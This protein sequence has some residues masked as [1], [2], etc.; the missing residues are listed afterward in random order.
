MIDH[1]HARRIK[2][3]QK[4]FARTFIP[5]SNLQGNLNQSVNKPE[6][7]LE[8]NTLDQIMAQLPEID[9]LIAGAAPER[10]IKDMNKLD[11]AVLRLIVFESRMKKT[12]IKVLINEAV[13]LA[14]EFGSDSS[15]RLVNGVLGTIFEL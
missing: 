15:P 14:K 13:E 3:L 7:E 9:E 6:L 8:P 10:P 12:P 2:L 11:L 5:A 1:R 4:L